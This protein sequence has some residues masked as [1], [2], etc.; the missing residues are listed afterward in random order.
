MAKPTEPRP[1][2]KQTPQWTTEAPPGLDL[3]T[4]T[5]DQANEVVAAAGFQPLSRGTVNALYRAGWGQASRVMYGETKEI[6]FKG[7]IG[8]TRIREVDAW[9]TALIQLVRPDGDMLSIAERAVHNMLRRRGVATD[10]AVIRSSQEVQDFR[11]LLLELALMVPH[12][13]FSSEMRQWL[14]E[15]ARA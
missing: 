13:P 9:R 4:T 8:L 7:S 5:I 10:A 3:G 2:M 1:E 6:L 11:E 15:V 14:L 12:R